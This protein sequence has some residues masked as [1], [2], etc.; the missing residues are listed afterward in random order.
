M[1]ICNNEIK[2]F[3]EHINEFANNQTIYKH[4][5]LIGDYLVYVFIIIIK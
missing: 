2:M 1:Q 3:S 4:Y 5:Q